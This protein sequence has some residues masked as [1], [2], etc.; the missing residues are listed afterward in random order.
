MDWFAVD[1]EGL[2]ALMERKGKTKAVLELIQN[3]WDEA[4]VTRV[5]MTLTAHERRGYS[6][7]VVEDDAPN[8]FEDLTDSFTMFAPSKKITDATKRGRFQLG[9]KLVLALCSEATVISNRGG[10]EFTAEGRKRLRR[11]RDAGSEFRA[12][13]R[14]T[15]A[16]RNEVAALVQTLLPPAGIVTTF[17]G[18]PLVHRDPLREFTT[19]LRTEVADADGILR[20]TRR[21]ATVRLFEP[22]GDETPHVYELGIPVVGVD[23]PWHVDVGQKVPLTFERDNVT[24]AYLRDLRV[25][26]LNATADLLDAEDVTATWVKDAAGDDRADTTALTQVFT[27]RFGDKAVAYDPSDPQ[28]NAEAVLHGYTVVHGGVLSRPE[29]TQVRRAG[30]LKP[31]G[32]VTPSP[33]VL[34]SPDGEPPLPRAQWTPGMTR[35]AD[36]AQALARELLGVTISVDIYSLNANHAAAYGGRH[37]S[38]NL[39]RLGHRWFNEPDP[40]AVD[41]LLIHEFA[42]HRVSDHLSERFHSECC[43]LGALLRN[44]TVRL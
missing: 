34:S 6:L 24:P 19:T 21:N 42:H 20:P 44:V 13:I 2:A 3:A 17:N 43:R 11:T 41:A 28:A 10:Y 16:E 4:G 38:F 22:L 15:A 7:L 30:L 36:Y 8:G 12:I 39:M 26:V 32:Q 14:L 33:K 1:K 29:W 25:A 35:V 9:E 37:L 40:A 18:R 23:L 27:K 31:A 5:H